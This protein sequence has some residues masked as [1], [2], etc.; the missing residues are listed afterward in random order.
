MEILALHRFECLIC[1]KSAI[2]SLVMEYFLW[3]FSPKADTRKAFIAKQKSNMHF[4]VNNHKQIK[5]IFFFFLWEIYECQWHPKQITKILFQHTKDAK[6][7]QLRH[8]KQHYWLNF[9]FIF[10][11]VISFLQLLNCYSQL[12]SRLIQ[13][14]P[15]KKGRKIY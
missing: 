4:V 10:Y 3:L 1:C 8:Q 6:Y 9:T 2:I 7:L 11:C 12:R 5:S 14:F 13:H 15:W